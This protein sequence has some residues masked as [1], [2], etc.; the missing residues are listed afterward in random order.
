MDYRKLQ[1]M[2]TDAQ[3]MKDAMDAKSNTMNEIIWRLRNAMDCINDYLKMIEDEP[4]RKEDLMKTIELS[5]R[6][7]YAY[8]EIAK[9]IQKA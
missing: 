6:Q 5:E 4:D 2:I 7:M 3:S 1:Q 9:A 8:M